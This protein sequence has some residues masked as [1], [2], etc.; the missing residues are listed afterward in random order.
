MQSPQRSTLHVRLSETLGECGRRSLDPE[1]C[2]DKLSERVWVN[3]RPPATGTTARRRGHDGTEYD[4]GTTGN[5]SDDGHRAQGADGGHAGC[6]GADRLSHR[7]PRRQPAHLRRP[8]AF[9][10]YSHG[11][12]SQSADLP[13]RGR[14]AAA[15]RR[16]PGSGLAVTW[17]AIAPARP[18]RIERNARAGHNSHKTLARPTMILSGLMRARLRPGAPRDFKFGPH[19]DSTVEPGVRDLIDWS[20]TSSGARCTSTWY[21]VAMTVIGFHLWHG[22]GS[23]FESLG[24]T[25]SRAAA[26]LRAGPGRRALRRLPA[27]SDRALPRRETG[28]DPGRQGAG[29]PLARSG[30]HTSSA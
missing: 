17:S 20:S 21:V 2:G 5:V 16:A 30:T 27:D 3:A 26:T 15:L 25:Y 13:G 11:L 4:R 7:S 28:G 9:N 19:Y 6:L 12:I 23:G 1:R 8:A 10:H 18:G 14:P 22:F 29:G 24:L